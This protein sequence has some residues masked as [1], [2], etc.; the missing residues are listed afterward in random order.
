MC[1]KDRF[2]RP[3]GEQI[4]VR[5]DASPDTT[6]G[7][8]VL[9]EKGKEKPARGTVFAVGSGYVNMGIRVPLEIKEG[10]KVIFGAYSGTDIIVDGEEFVV[11]READVLAAIR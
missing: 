2:I 1:V 8:I 7:G 5:R 11:I 6:P 10:E 4:L 9:P 3:V